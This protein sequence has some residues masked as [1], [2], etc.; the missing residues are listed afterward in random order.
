MSFL[1][2]QETSKTLPPSAYSQIW[3][4]SSGS[5]PRSDVL[6]LALILHAIR[7][8]VH[9]A[10]QHCTTHVLKC[11]PDLRVTSSKP[12][13]RR[14]TGPF[15]SLVFSI[16]ELATVCISTVCGVDVLRGAIGVEFNDTREAGG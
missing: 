12:F 7:V 15:L 2:C 6:E 14:R 5:R 13:S 1:E 4:L 3:F 8:L 11:L 10:K 16:R 9:L